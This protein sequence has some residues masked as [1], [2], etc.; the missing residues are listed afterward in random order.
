MC[1]VLYCRDLELRWRVW[2]CRTQQA[3]T[4]CVSVSVD[5]CALGGCAAR[6]LLLLS[7]LPQLGMDRHR[8]RSR[9]WQ[10]CCY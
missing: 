6:L 10:R 7:P 8:H 9:Q 3:R 5:A 2:R 4:V 1:T